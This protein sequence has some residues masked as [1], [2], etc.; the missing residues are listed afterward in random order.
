MGIIVTK[1]TTPISY[2][3]DV[4]EAALEYSKEIDGK[5]ALTLF[6][7]STKFE[8]YRQGKAFYSLLRD[9]H[10]EVFT[11]PT[12]FLYRLLELLKLRESMELE[13]SNLEGAMWKSKLNYSFRRNVFEHLKSAEKREKAQELLSACNTM[14]DTQP[15]VS[16]MVLSEFIYK[17]RKTA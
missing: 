4:S 8:T 2:L 6:G 5:D 15:E 3:A 11:L 7:R 13:G 10:T 9:V 14:I 1:P 17:R 16:R 12:A